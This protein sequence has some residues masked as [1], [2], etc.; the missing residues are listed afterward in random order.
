MALS[1]LLVG[2]CVKIPSPINASTGGEDD[3]FVCPE[4]NALGVAD[5]VSSWSQ[6]GGNSSHYSRS[7]MK[8]AHQFSHLPTPHEILEMAWSHVDQE[9]IG[10]TTATLVKLD[11]Q[12]LRTVSIG[13]SSCSVFRS[14]KRGW[15]TDATMNGFND[16]IQLGTN[17]PA[18]PRDIPEESI[19][20]KANDVI[21]CGSD[22]L[23]DNLEVSEIETLMKEVG[24]NETRIT[25]FVSETANRLAE[26]ASIVSQNATAETPFAKQSRSAGFPY[27]G[28]KVGD[29][30][31]V[32]GV[33]SQQG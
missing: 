1:L 14:L 10:A 11:G 9:I 31:V 6:Y 4:H 29:V 13:D 2:T 12:K 17:S 26:T 27:T 21:I 7:I 23:W 22:G 33:V 5:G 18:E 8:S 19:N 16:P 28:G 20:V 15:Y 30:T 32:V 3:C 24:Y 25:E